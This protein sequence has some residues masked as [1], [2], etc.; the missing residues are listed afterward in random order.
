M[1]V[2]E[3]VLHKPF[4]AG[5]SIGVPWFAA[6]L[7][8]GYRRHARIV[9]CMAAF[10]S[11]VGSAVL[12]ADAPNSESLYQALM[13][14]FSCLTFGATLL[15]PRRDCTTGAIG[16]ILFF[17]LMFFAGLW[18]PQQQMGA[19]LRSISQYTPLGAAVPSIINSD[20]GHWPGTTHLLVLAGYT[21]IMLRIAVRFFRWDR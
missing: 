9:G 12:L 15:L 13:L 5:V 6:V 11:I 18:V 16:G 2:P 1:S 10:T 3:W 21:V 14:L 19:T 17:P 8:T 20:F 7:L 4:L